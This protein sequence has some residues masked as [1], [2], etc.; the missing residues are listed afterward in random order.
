M[1]FKSLLGSALV[2]SAC[3]SDPVAT[4]DAAVT[5]TGSDVVA[6]DVPTT[7]APRADVPA[8]DT[9][10]AD[11]PA[12]D[13]PVADAP[14]TDAPAADATAA[15]APV[16]ANDGCTA[17]AVDGAAVGTDCA[18]GVTCPT[19]YRCTTFSGIVA[20][21]RCQIPC[22]TDCDC[23]GAFA[24]QPVRDKAGSQNLCVRR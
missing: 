1:R 21:M 18:R 7:D 19:G 5:D 17:P 6:T 14:A 15:D 16:A 12:A 4:H 2:L 22:A 11:T 23:P 20:Q 8:I 10:A 24:C 9:P 13:V 3:G